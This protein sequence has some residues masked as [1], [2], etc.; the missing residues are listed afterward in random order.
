MGKE[1]IICERGLRA[2][3]RFGSPPTHQIR[4]SQ[5]A[6]ANKAEISSN[7]RFFP[8]YLL[9]L[10]T[11]LRIQSPNLDLSMSI[12]TRR[13]G[14]NACVVCDDLDFDSLLVEERRGEKRSRARC[15]AG[16][17]TLHRAVFFSGSHL[18]GNPF[19]RVKTPSGVPW[20]I[21]R[22]GFVVMLDR[23]LF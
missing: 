23:S 7:P 17:G 20:T 5:K 6:A 16:E 19:S 2:P 13:G 15:A 18:P 12:N 1:S 9:S 11:S 21:D 14:A 4:C 3:R 22:F 8:P 10:T